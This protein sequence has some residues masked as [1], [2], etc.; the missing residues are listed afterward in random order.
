[1]NSL[2]DI[3]PCVL[4]GRIVRLEPLLLSHVSALAEVGLEP[5]LWRLQPRSVTSRSE[6]EA[7]VQVAL[8][9]QRRGLSLPFV[10]ARRDTE[11]IVGTSRYMEIAPEHRRLE[12]GATWITAAYQRTGVNVEAKLLLLAHAFDVLGV[13]KVVFKTEAANTQSREAI[14]A[15]GAREEGI[16]RSHLLADDGRPRDMV[17]FSILEA[18]WPAVRRRN[19]GRLPR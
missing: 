3:K 9:D 19:E 15:L 6:M 16:L 8:D 4:E 10:I 1:M 11:V 14:L 18:E 2:E 5:A 12:I 7:Y 17:F 13:R